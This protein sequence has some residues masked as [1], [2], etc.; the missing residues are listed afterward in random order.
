MRGS[1][2]AAGAVSPLGISICWPDTMPDI[3]GLMLRSASSTWIRQPAA[4]RQGERRDSTRVESGRHLMQTRACR[5]L[6]C[7]NLGTI[8]SDPIQKS[9][10]A[11][12]HPAVTKLCHHCIFVS[13]SHSFQS[14]HGRG[15]RVYICFAAEWSPAEYAWVLRVLRFASSSLDEGARF[16]RPTHHNRGSRQLSISVFRN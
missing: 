11:G 7:H 1:F 8:M 12:G 16:S 14:W 6:L 10:Y 3:G 2:H 9:R 4:R 5:S 15:G 13:G